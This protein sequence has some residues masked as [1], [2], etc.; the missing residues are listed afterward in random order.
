MYSKTLDFVS[1]CKKFFWNTLYFVHWMHFCAKTIKILQIFPSHPVLNMYWNEQVWPST[2]WSSENF[3][4]LLARIIPSQH[5]SSVNHCGNPPPCEKL[6]PLFCF[7]LISSQS[8]ARHSSE[9][10]QTRYAVCGTFIEAANQMD[11]Y[12]D[13]RDPKSGKLLP[14]TDERLDSGLDSLREDEYTS[15]ECEFRRMELSH[16]GQE[17]EEPWKKYLTEDGDT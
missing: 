16:V 8:L 9:A 14:N 1:F 4:K 3:P 6:R 11:Y 2:E 17:D 13:G 15:V 10:Q 12:A 5:H 7:A